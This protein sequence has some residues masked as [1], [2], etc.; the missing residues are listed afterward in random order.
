MEE[1][2]MS[3]IARFEP[4]VRNGLGNTWSGLDRLFEDVLRDVSWPAQTKTKVDKR[5]PATNVNEVEDKYEISV[6]APGLKKTDFNITLE[7][8]LLTVS[9]ESEEK[10]AHAL[11]QDTFNYNWET[12]QGVMGEDVTAKYDAGILKVFVNKP[13]SQQAAVEKIK[14]K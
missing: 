2:I 14:V 9:Y 1:Y 8:N 6:V 5:S 3:T 4:Y 10:D 13:A 12:P 7:N 11:S